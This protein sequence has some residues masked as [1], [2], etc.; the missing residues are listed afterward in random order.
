MKFFCT[1]SDY[2]YLNQGLVLYE[3]LKQYIGDD[4]LLY[5]LCIDKKTYDK[6]L[7]LKLDKVEPIFAGS[8][9]E[10]TNKQEK[11]S[12]YCWSLASRFC[13]YLI[14]SKN[15]PD[16]LYIDSDICFYRD[17]EVVYEEIGNKSIGIVPHRF[18]HNRESLVG[19]YNVGIVYFRNDEPGKKCLDFWVDCVTNLNN[20]YRQKYGTCGDQKYLELFPVKFADNLCI[21]QNKVSYGA[22]WSFFIYDYGKF[23]SDNRVVKYKGKDYPF[24]FSHFSQFTCDYMKGTYDLKGYDKE[25]FLKIPEVKKLY[26]EYYEW[27]KQVYER[28]NLGL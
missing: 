27:N 12:E 11:Y 20:K 21:I 9:E 7:G 8:C 16:I 22:P 2:N 10:L 18:D 14:A 25:S 17:V 3:S 19:R 4:F 5:Y 24:V 23:N 13:Q 15:V 1:L 28:Y 26:G 6:V